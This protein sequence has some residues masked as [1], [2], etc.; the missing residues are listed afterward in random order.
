MLVMIFR[1]KYCVHFF[2]AATIWIFCISVTPFS[3]WILY[4]LESQYQPFQNNVK[5]DSP[6][7]ILILGGG[8]TMAPALPASGQVFPATLGR[9]TEG[10]RIQHQVPGSKL[11][12]SGNSTSTSTKITQAEVVANAAIELGIE[13]RD[14]IQLRPPTNTRE[15]IKAYLKRFGF[16]KNVIIVTNAYHMPR[17]MLICKQEGLKAISAPTDYCLKKDPR[18]TL[19]DFRPSIFKIFMFDYAMHEYLGMIKIKWWD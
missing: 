7:Y 11:V 8:F 13:P 18:K 15:E 1:K 6:T 3:Q 4:R 5:L 9:L 16:G 12:C 19:F 14:T 2:A 10:I 17:T